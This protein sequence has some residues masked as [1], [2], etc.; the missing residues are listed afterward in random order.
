MARVLI[1]HPDLGVTVERDDRSLHVWEALGWRAVTAT[2]APAG[3]DP[4]P[5]TTAGGDDPPPRR[6]RRQRP[7]PTA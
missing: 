2:S 7:D 1:E 4:P 6:A 3:D 5:D